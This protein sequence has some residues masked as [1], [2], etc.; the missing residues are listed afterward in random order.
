MAPKA[1]VTKMS[2]RNSMTSPMRV[3]GT[4]SPCPRVAHRRSSI[5]AALNLGWRRWSSRIAARLVCC[6]RR[7]VIGQTVVCTDHGDGTA[8]I[9]HRPPP[10]DRGNDVARP[11]PGDVRRPRHLPEQQRWTR[12]APV[13]HLALPSART[14]GGETRG[15]PRRG[16]ALSAVHGGAA[17][18]RLRHLDRAA[19]AGGTNVVVPAPPED[20]STWPTGTVRSRRSTRT[21]SGST[22]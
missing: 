12:Q 20:R 15:D 10:E 17:R 11:L 22:A 1:S 2:R 13:R 9:L 5:T 3:R 16:R 19:P 14:L 7:G 8:T 4:G 18:R 21:P 6:G